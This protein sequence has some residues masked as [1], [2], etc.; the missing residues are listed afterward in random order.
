MRFITEFELDYPFTLRATELY[1]ENMELKMG[2]MIAK[3]FNWKERSFE[4]H[5]NGETNRWSLEI[6][7]FPMDK[8][9]E[10]KNKLFTYLDDELMPSSIKILEM[11]KE[12]EF[13]GKPSSGDAIT[14]Q[15]L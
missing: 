2:S 7:A 8:W 15:Q 13:Y 10:F 5:K 14:N 11:I 9:I 4:N 1:K 3:D 12:L 6:E